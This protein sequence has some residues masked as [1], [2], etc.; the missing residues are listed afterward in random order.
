MQSRSLRRRSA[1]LAVACSVPVFAAS[2]ELEKSP[3]V[4]G[5]TESVPVLITLDEPAGAEVRPLRLAV[6][7]GSFSA[8][9]RL[10][11]GRYRSV[12]TPPS[13]RFPQVALVAVWRETGP[14]AEIQ[15]LRIPLFGSTKLP[16]GAK[17]DS[18][19]SLVVGDQLFG[20][21]KA[22]GRPLDVRIVV[23]PGLATA[24]LKVR[25]PNGNTLEKELPIDVPPYNRVTAALVPHAIVADGK[26]RARL[27]I[28]YDGADAT[29]HPSRVLVTASVGTVVFERASK[30]RFVYWYQPP[31]DTSGAT[32]VEFS[33]A[34]EGD[35]SAK[36]RAQLSLGLAA[37]ARVVVRPP[38]RQLQA[39]GVTR[40]P[41]GV[42]VLDAEGLGL[43][44]Q[45]VSLTANG[46]PVKGL[47]YQG[48]GLYEAPF[49][50]PGAY[51][52]GGLVQFVAAVTGLEGARLQGVANYTVAATALPKEL[53]FRLVPS[54]VPADGRSGAELYLDVRSEAG[55]P[56]SGAKL[57]AL[58]SHGTLGPLVDEGGGRYRAVYTAPASIPEGDALIRVVDDTGAY[59]RRIA[60]PM[61]EDPKR[62]LLG[63]RGGVVHG[64]SD[65]VGPRA[66]LDLSL[67]VKAGPTLVWLSLA[68]EAGQAAQSVSDAAG[69]ETTQSTLVFVPVTVRVAVELWASRRL[70]LQ[71]GAGGGAFWARYSTSLT[72]ERATAF[73]PDVAGFF[74]GT[75]SVGPGHFFLEASY[76][77]APVSGP[78]FRADAGGLGAILGYRLGVF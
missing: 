32:S 57:V 9:Q 6:N 54:P 5:Q 75:L 18:K 55:L 63:V 77:W 38:A 31:A 29:P 3:V 1:L 15:F 71:L 28:F 4:L 19:I 22:E 60:L 8:V 76:A 21:L 17:K 69:V 27:D 61:R 12:Y 11:P 62:L 35:L 59:E 44:E 25:E 46:E 70:A 48:N 36:A 66:G 45:R 50:A 68:G 65:M 73:G 58:A 64:L 2:L 78:G 47:A 10:G 67:P 53:A 13:T 37:P 43:P 52:P 14:D 72:H 49:L 56:L 41:V 42:V 7:V 51:P 34:I 16:I 24:E 39:D 74:G 20:P 30:G 33:V 26:S 23:P 40:V